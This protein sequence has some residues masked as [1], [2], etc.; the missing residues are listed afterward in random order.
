MDTDA[1]TAPTD[2]EARRGAR[3]SRAVRLL[4]T[5]VCVL[6]VAEGTVRALESRLPPAPLWDTDEYPQKIEQMDALAAAGGAGTVLL[7]SSVMDVSVDPA[8]LAPVDGRPAY[9]AGLIG[10]T[11]FIV[12]IWS[13]Y[14]VELTLQ[15]SVVV[16]AVSSRDV[17]ING[18][19]LESSDGRFLDAPAVKDLLGDQT[20]FDEVEWALSQGSALVRNRLLLR[21][22]LE[23]IF[24]Y[25]APDRNATE[26]SPGGMETHLLAT[27]YRD[28]EVVRDFFRREPLRS[29]EISANQ[30]DALR[31]L[32]TRLRENG[33]RVVILDV[34]V[35]E[36]YIELHP[37]GA[38]DYD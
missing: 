28:D 18:I 37:Q 32:A 13:R 27:N 31:R 7:G 1:A 23:S 4:L 15:P 5:V 9:N 20:L 33:A 6:L 24:G 30:V 12:D 34:P 29:F 21:R 11:P 26:I 8:A 10:A 14:L 2:P 22:P 36:D 16:I 3:R 17:N 35:T 25:D 38:A 19:G